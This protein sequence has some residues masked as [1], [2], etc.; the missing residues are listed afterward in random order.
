[1]FTPDVLRSF[2]LPR[3][4]LLIFFK[5]SD[6][7]TTVDLSLK[8]KLLILDIRSTPTPLQH[9]LK[10]FHY[11]RSFSS[12]L[13]RTLIVCSPLVMQTDCRTERILP[14]LCLTEE[15][16]PGDPGLS[17]GINKLCYEYLV[18][19]EKYGDHGYGH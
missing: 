8:Q 2:L 12:L 11:H 18:S 16:Y 10:G 14:R 5:I 19:M 17:N 6:I 15:S 13:L 1:M 9:P 4:S 3:F 7:V